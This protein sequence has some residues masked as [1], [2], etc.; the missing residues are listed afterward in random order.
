MVFVAF[1]S[2]LAPIRS[3]V[4][5]PRFN[6]AINVMNAW[7]LDRCVLCWIAVLTGLMGW[8]VHAPESHARVE[9][10]SFSAR[11]DGQGY[12]IRVH[13][14]EPITAYGMPTRV[15]KRELTWT[16]YNT[17][18][19]KTFNQG[20]SQGPVERFSAEVHD[21]HLTLHFYLKA[22]RE[23]RSAAYRDRHSNDLLLGLTYTSA[24]APVRTVASAPSERGATQPETER[25]QAETQRTT[26]QN[27]SRSSSRDRWKL[28][29]VVIDP[30]H[31]GRDPGTQGHGLNEKDIVLDVSKRLGDYLEEKLG[32]NVVYTRTTD[33]FVELKQ[34][35]RIANEAGGKLFVSVHANAA[36]SHRA[37]GTETF[38]LGMHKTAA[39]KR[40]MERENKVVKMEDNPEQYEEL[41]EEALVRYEL[42]QSMNMQQSEALA[43]LV[44]EQFANRVHR[45]SRGVKQAG[46]RVLW[47]ASMPAVLV[48]L[49]FLSNYGD[50]Q[51]L[52]SENGKVYMASALYRAV[53]DY[54]E[55]YE[56][57]MNL[58]RSE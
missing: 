2:G 44:E 14:S 48:E 8:A 5:A 13:T 16:L 34:R 58:V 38:F 57:G 47:G 22:D 28:D 50:A 17:S 37:R 39:A 32:L 20:R 49:G 42:T 24:G 1:P 21:G 56:K 7:N 26:A 12:V 15:G 33:E 25:S 30:G 36:R 31:G 45:K 27:A 41:D 29:T 52:G 54:K 3:L 4:D 55:E 6:A 23:V 53:R 40:V 11:S 35:G 19:A 43:K 18:L 10:I 51:F 9:D 46:F